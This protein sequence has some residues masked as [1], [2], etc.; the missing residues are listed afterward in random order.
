VQ[1]V[2]CCCANKTTIMHC[3]CCSCTL[4]QL[5]CTPLFDANIDTNT[6]I[7]IFTAATTGRAGREVLREAILEEENEEEEEEGSGED[8]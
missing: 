3:S 7:T 1:H 6:L 5:E 4:L 2:A 8:E